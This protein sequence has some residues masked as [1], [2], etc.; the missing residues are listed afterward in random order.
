[1]LGTPKG[2]SDESICSET[3]S[4]R[5]HRAAALLALAAGCGGSSRLSPSAYRAKL[6]KIGREANTAQ[7]QVEQG[8]QAKSVAEIRTRLTT[9]ANA[10]QKLGDEVAALKPPKN[11][12]AANALLARGEH[13]TASA[14]RAVLPHLAKLRSVKAALSLLNKS[15]GNAKGGRELDQ[16]LTELKRMG[17]AKGS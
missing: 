14:T 3:P 17:Y 5:R 2:G 10:T 8:L 12:E 4:R 6:A 7:S 13:D 16:A 11:A 15:Q 9:F 1:L